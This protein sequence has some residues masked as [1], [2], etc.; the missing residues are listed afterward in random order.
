MVGTSD[1]V[2]CFSIG[3][4]DAEFNSFNKHQL[5]YSQWSASDL[6]L[7]KWMPTDKQEAQHPISIGPLR[8]G[9]EKRNNKDKVLI[10]ME[11]ETHS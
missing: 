6:T 2:S 10:T 3:K 1:A 5:S 8:P 4:E 11:I 9:Q 7:T